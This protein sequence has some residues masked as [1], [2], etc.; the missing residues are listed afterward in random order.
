MMGLWSFW[1]ILAVGF[2]AIELLTMSTVC[3]YVGAGALA[4]MICAILGGEWIAAILTFGIS[5]ILLYLLTYKWR[6]TLIT[7]LHRT[8]QPT[9]TGMDAI[10]GRTGRLVSFPDSLRVK[11]DGDTWK[12][13][14]V[15]EEIHLSAGEAVRVVAYDS[16]ILVVEPLT[17]KTNGKQ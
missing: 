11:I 3:P 10:I 16:I 6:K 14:P 9:L 17:N 7:S 2:F 13:R 5:T 1:L 4:A 12:V 8:S 15:E